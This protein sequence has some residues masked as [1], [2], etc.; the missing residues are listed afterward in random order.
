MPTRRKPPRRTTKRTRETDKA[1]AFDALQRS[2]PFKSC[3]KSKNPAFCD[4]PLEIVTEI[5]YLVNAEKEMHKLAWE[6]PD[7]SLCDILTKILPA[8]CIRS[9]RITRFLG[10]GSVGY[11]FG[12]RCKISSKTGALKIQKVGRNDDTKQEI[13]LHKKFSKLGLSPDM[14][15]NCTLVKNRRKLSFLNMDRIDTT[16]TQWLKKKHTKKLLNVLINRIFDILTVMRKKGVTHGDLHSDNIGFVFK[17]TSEEPGRIQIIDH[18]YA[19]TNGAMTELEIVQFMRT[20][21]R[22]F[23]PEIHSESRAHLLQ[24]CQAEAARIYGY[25]V[26]RSLTWLDHRFSTLRGRLRRMT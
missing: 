3:T 9:W 19:N 22:D 24:R 7:A 13:R 1:T 12:C 18:S 21:H 4:V 15:S 14:H 16:L 6:C 20:L 10:E 23:S 11:V 17:R 5:A 8:R 26:S 25:R 2:R